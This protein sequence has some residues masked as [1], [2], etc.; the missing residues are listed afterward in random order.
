M[1]NQPIDKHAYERLHSEVAELL[2]K[3]DSPARKT[4]EIKPLFQEYQNFQTRQEELKSLEIR[5]T[6]MIPVIEQAEVEVAKAK[7]QLAE[8]EKVLGTFAEE[9]GRSVFTGF[10][11][12]VIPDQLI[13]GPRKELQTRLDELQAKRSSLQSQQRTGLLEKTKQQA[14]LLALA[15]QIKF[16]EVNVGSTD[17][18][19]GEAIL[20]S[21]EKLTIKCSYTEQVLKAIIEQQQRIAPARG[22]LKSAEELVIQRKA[23]CGAKLGR[24]AVQSS[25]LKSEL[26]EHRGEAVRN[27]KQMNSLRDQVV[28][29]AIRSEVAILDVTISLKLRE[30][31]KLQE[32]R[33]ANRFQFAN[34]LGS[35][36]HLW[37]KLPAGKRRTAVI[38]GGIVLGFL[39][40]VFLGRGM[41]SN[42]KGVQTA[43][44]AVDGRQSSKQG[45]NTSGNPQ[46]K[47]FANSIGMKLR[48]IPKGTFTMGSP[49]SE[50]GRSDHERPH[51]VTISR[52]FYM[53][54]YEV[55]QEEYQKVMGTNP[56]Y[57]QDGKDARFK[58][59]DTSKHPVEEVTWTDANA[60]CSRLSELPEEKKAGRVYRLPTESEWEYACRSGSQAA[61][62]FGEN[63]G[64]L[65]DAAW[66][67][68]NSGKNELDTDDLKEKREDIGGYTLSLMANYCRTQIVGMK[69]PNAWGL[70]DMHGNVRE[71]CLD[72]FTFYPY[73]AVT[74][75]I[76]SEKNEARV[77]RGGSYF[78]QANRCRS[79]YREGNSPTTRINTIGFRV[80]LIPGS[81]DSAATETPSVPKSKNPMSPPKEAGNSPDL[82]Q[83]NARKRWRSPNEIYEEMRSIDQE[84]SRDI[85]YVEFQIARKVSPSLYQ[86]MITRFPPATEILQIP[87][88]IKTTE[89]EYNSMGKASLLVKYVKEESLS[90]EDGFSKNYIFFEEIAGGTTKDYD[91]HWASLKMQYRSL[92]Q[93]LI[94]TILHEQPTKPE[95]QFDLTR[96]ITLKPSPKLGNKFSWGQTFEPSRSASGVLMKSSLGSA[97]LNVGSAWEKGFDCV[98]FAV[99]DHDVELLELLLLKGEKI[100]SKGDAADRLRELAK[101]ADSRKDGRKY[102]ERFKSNLDKVLDFLASH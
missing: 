26:K 22:K 57:F 94:A 4:E 77:V 95:G 73:D 31:R 61:Y 84:S 56:S 65:R 40:L 25:D 21:K 82:V 27:T 34:R 87:A 92:A 102:G 50:K 81:L 63:E 17:R 19:V 64:S 10:Q 45:E 18:L 62:E 98:Q 23:E 49:A 72:G 52:G 93:E 85:R 76:G 35:V 71:W 3:P 68:N 80:A 20:S 29:V 2:L 30:L 54:V 66:F 86:C 37:K 75:P 51:E 9:L 69:K 78:D 11:A 33:A 36:M 89:T 47:E 97:L 70:Y 42:G 16:E 101:Q 74:D 67:G 41:F 5:I 90:T 12:G 13:L 6:E 60:F 58:K 7:R 48:L 100:P 55:T 43:E 59:L 28:D 8:E 15:G 38:A 32:S 79:A 99:F 1:E 44:T 46:P 91:T 53:G 14:H 83:Q 96:M 39:L 88:I 24:A